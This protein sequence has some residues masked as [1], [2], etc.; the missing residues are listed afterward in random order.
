MKQRFVSVRQRVAASGVLVIVTPSASSTSALPLLL[1][2][3]RLPCLA[4]RTPPAAATSAAAVEMLNVPPPS[5][6]VPHVSSSPSPHISSRIAF[7]RIVSTNPTISSTV[8]PFIRRAVKKPAICIGCAS[9]SIISLI[10]SRA[11]SRVS[12]SPC[13]T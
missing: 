5:P 9:P 2:T 12:D 1:D 3:A 6:P 10:A 7:S 4:T 11:S 13:A 8:S